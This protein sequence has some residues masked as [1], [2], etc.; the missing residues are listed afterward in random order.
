[1][2]FCSAAICE[3]HFHEEDVITKGKLKFLRCGAKP[4]K[5]LPKTSSFSKESKR[6]PSTEREYVVKQYHKNLKD[7][8]KSYDNLNSL[9]KGE[10]VN[11][12][13]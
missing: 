7:V 13:L 1:M 8:L 4:F 10:T 6:K 2:I 11:E 12:L 5:N 3:D 9:V